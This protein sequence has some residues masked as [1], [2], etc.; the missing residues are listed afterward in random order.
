MGPGMGGPRAHGPRDGR[1]QGPWGHGPRA[2]GWEGPGPGPRDGRARARAQ[3]WEGPGPGPG[4]GGPR[5]GP[6]D[7]RARARA[8]AQR[9][10][11]SRPAPAGKW[12]NMRKRAAT[13]A[14]KGG[15]TPGPI[16]RPSR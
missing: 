3:G 5:P 1:A 6:R 7:G 4:M 11:W 16:G 8:W 10:A 9:L 15:P 12:V 2:Q 13:A 14:R